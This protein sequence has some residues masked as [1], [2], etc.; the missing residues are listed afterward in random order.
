MRR[1][2]IQ[3][4]NLNNLIILTNSFSGHNWKRHIKIYLRGGDGLSSCFFFLLMDKTGDFFLYSKL[5]QS[6]NV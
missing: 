2:S 3:D 1:A 5:T 4:T 6:S